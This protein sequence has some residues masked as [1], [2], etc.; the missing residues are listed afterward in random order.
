LDNDGDIDA[1]IANNN[2]PAN[3]LIRDGTPNGNWIGFNLVG[4]KSNRD[5]IG[6][7][8]LIETSETTQTKYI[9]TA[10]SYLAANDKRLL[11]G[12]GDN[13]S[14]K[15]ITIQWPNGQSNVYS[16]L[17]SNRYYQ[18]IEGGEIS[19]YHY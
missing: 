17:K 12:L 18:I 11:F 9:N 13:S 10:G 7:R 16:N 8:A 4:T 15:T 3:L 14:V 5:A 6:A 1:V 19:E 2:E